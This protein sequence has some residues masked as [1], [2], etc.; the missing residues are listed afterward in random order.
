MM[1]KIYYAFVVFATCM[2]SITSSMISLEGKSF[3]ITKS[4]PVL[5]EKILLAKVLTSNII[6]IPVVLIC[7]IIFF[8]VFKVAILDIV[9]ILLASIIMPTFTA[10]T[11]I[12]MNLK[13]PKMDATSDTEVV[14]QSMS[15]TVSVFLGMFVG[16]LS[17][18]IIILGSKINLDLFIILELLIFGAIVFTLWRI[19]KKYGVKRFREINV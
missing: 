19:L 1:P 17:I 2:T 10:L 4:L 11:G 12:L 16:M 18:A 3:N 14:K 6:S 9:F 13:Y 15:S 8:V 7:D 5:P